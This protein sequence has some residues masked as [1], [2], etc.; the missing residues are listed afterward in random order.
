M[1][2]DLGAV[3]VKS[4]T[5]YRDS[6]TRNSSDIDG[7]PAN[8]VGAT[9]IF[10]QHQ[11]SEEL[12]LSGT[13]DELDWIGG[14]FYFDEGGH[15]V[16]VS[17]VLGVL[18]SPF[19]LSDAS[20]RAKSTGIFGQLIYH[21]TDSLR[22]TVG[23]R[24]T[25]DE[26]EINRHGLTDIAAGI[27]AVGVNIGTAAGSDCNDPHSARFHYPAW[28][29]GLDYQL[30]EDLFVYA[31]TSGAALAGGF[32]SRV[33]PPGYDAFAPEKVKDIEM[34]FKA[35]LLD[36]KLRTNTALFYSWRNNV[37]NIVNE[38]NNGQLTQ[39]QRNAGKVEAYGAEFEGTLLP[40]D[41]MEITTAAA[42]LHAAYVKGSFEVNGLGGP[43]DRSDER[44]NQAPK[45]TAS[46]GATQSFDS[47]WGR[48]SFHIDYSYVASRSYYQDTPDPNN[49]AQSPA[50]Y[51]EANRLGVLGGY[52]VFNARI[53][54]NVDEPDI[55]VSFWARNLTDTKYYQ[56]EF[57]S[58]TGLG[59]AAEYQGTPRTYGMTVGYH[60]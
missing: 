3:D 27:C 5:A 33:T 13:V 53:G 31:K 49:P 51:A 2:L 23:A 52:G 39:Y 29:A 8:L 59:I 14:F 16:S 17:Q 58:W 35:D 42:Y 38:L 57:N 40:W 6:D 28:T 55:E 20:F 9:G 50:E 26:R 36:R 25:W 48:P 18:G 12:Q 37:Q 60:W 54:L 10:Q 44:V 7:T 41:G 15:E 21:L 45:W 56:N 34:G 43:V 19:N 1:E 24:Y 22:A 46:L 11:F 47:L 4:I 32:N 30:A